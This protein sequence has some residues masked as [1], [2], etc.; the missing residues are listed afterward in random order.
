MSEIVSVYETDGSVRQVTTPVRR[1]AELT[2]GT[3]ADPEALLIALQEM[4]RVVDELQRK[5]SPR[6]IVKRLK[7]PTGASYYTDRIEHGL[8]A[9]VIARLECVESAYAGWL[10]PG[11]NLRQDLSDNNT[12]VVHLLQSATVEY[13]AVIGI[14]VM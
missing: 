1:R 3:V 9:P 11:L 6:R 14:E 10:S 4:S 8:G 2:S 7:V 5:V 12:I 13:I